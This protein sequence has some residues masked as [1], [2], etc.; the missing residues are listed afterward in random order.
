MHISFQSEQ[1]AQKLIDFVSAHEYGPELHV[2]I[3]RMPGAK[4]GIELSGL[5]EKW[6]ALLSDVFYAF[7]MEDRLW[8]GLEQAVTQ[9]YHFTE[10]EEIEAIMEIAGSIIEGEKL[11]GDN[12]EMDAARLLIA[13]SLKPVITAGLSFSFESF[14]TFRLKPLLDSAVRYAEKAIDEYKLE[15]EYQSFQA[16]LRDCLQRQK[17][18]LD[19]L[20]VRHEGSSMTFY[21]PDRRRLSHRELQGMIDKKLFSGTLMYLDSTAL[22]PLISIAPS[23]LTI[24]TDEAEDGLIQTIIRLF[25]ERIVIRKFSSFSEG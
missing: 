4:I 18:K 20:Y 5:E 23:H 12:E 11:A 2:Y 14:V 17:P 8:Q 9:R 15:Q 1:E 22:A 25:E 13:E 19:R 21:D 24:Y 3:S 7:F 10:R 6:H 16:A